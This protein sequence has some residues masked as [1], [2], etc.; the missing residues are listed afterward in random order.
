M[1]DLHGSSYSVD[2]LGSL[3]ITNPTSS[4]SMT[5]Q[6][7]QTITL[8]KVIPKPLSGQSLTIQMPYPQAAFADPVLVPKFFIHQVV[9]AV[10]SMAIA[11]FPAAY[12]LHE[13]SR[14]CP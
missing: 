13:M 2:F 3:T 10:H 9:S 7:N 5:Q 6:Q 8:I 1:K 4:L 14:M 11:L 12:I